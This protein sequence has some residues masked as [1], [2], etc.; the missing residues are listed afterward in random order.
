M[1]AKAGTEAVVKTAEQL[2]KKPEPD[3]TVFVTRSVPIEI[4][5]KMLHSALLSIPLLFPIL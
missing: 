2:Q 4:C 5:V 3:A 1:L